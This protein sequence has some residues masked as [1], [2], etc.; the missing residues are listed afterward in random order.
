MNI[1]RNCELEAKI[2][3]FQQYAEHIYVEKSKN[4]FICMSL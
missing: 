2:E 3:S 4:G 1:C